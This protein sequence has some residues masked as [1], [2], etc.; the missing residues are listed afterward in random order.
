MAVPLLFC[1]M[2]L[3]LPP[4]PPATPAVPVAGVGVPIQQQHDAEAHERLLEAQR[5]LEQGRS[6]PAL[7]LLQLALAKDPL[8]SRG[9][10]LVGRLLQENGDISGALQAYRSALSLDPQLLPAWL[11]V[12]T[13]FLASGRYAEATAA[14]RQVTP[15]EPDNADAWY[16]LGAALLRAD[17]AQEAVAPLR[18][19]NALHPDWARVLRDLGVA[20]LESGNP[21]A[22]AEPLRRAAELQPDDAETRLNLVRLQA[23]RDPKGAL[24]ALQ[25]LVDE[26]AEFTDAWLE[27]GEQYLASDDPE[28]KARGP[29]ALRRARELAPDDPEIHQRLIEAYW[30]LG[31]NEDVY[32]ELDLLLEKHPDYAAGW[33]VL[34]NYQLSRKRYAQATTAYDHALSLQPDLSVTHF[35][36]AEALERLQ[37]PE[38]SRT[39]F[40]KALALDPNL[41]MAAVG[42]ARTSLAIGEPEAALEALQKVSPAAAASEVNRLR[43]RS[44]LRLQRYREASVQLRIAVQRNPEDRDAWATLAQALERQ[45]ERTGA[46]QALTRAREISR[47]EPGARAETISAGVPKRGQYNLLRARVYLHEGRPQEALRYLREAMIFFAD[48]PELK[49]LREEAL[50][51]LGPRLGPFT[52][53]AATSG[54]TT[55]NRSGTREKGFLVETTGSGAAWLDYDGDGRDDL[56]LANGNGVRYLPLGNGGNAMEVTTRPPDALMRQL[57]QAGFANVAATAGVADL[58]WAGGVAVGDLDNDGWPDLFITNGT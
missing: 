27:L 26:H 15:K 51:A 16:G 1:S 14:F 17:R 5:L 41:A 22:A 23:I 42:I 28:L 46:A 38:E 20:L 53:V 32:R 8:H 3:F 56:F 50:A 49:R 4:C 37:Q 9:W 30:K 54:L 58:G 13:L 35:R 57:P 39:A 7:A 21:E 31:F 19:A 29:A 48:D 45:G 24:E 12:G 43:G 40:R 11:H 55:A 47:K 52:D 2:L 44:Y 33:V 18:K 10:M 36:R 25:G 34:G 6:E